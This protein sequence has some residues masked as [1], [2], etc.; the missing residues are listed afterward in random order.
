MKVEDSGDVFKKG[1]VIDSFCGRNFKI[2]LEEGICVSAV[3]AGRLC[4]HTKV[5]RG[6]EVMV[7][8]TPYNNFENGIITERLTKIPVENVVHKQDLNRGRELKAESSLKKL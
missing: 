7:R 6:D 3:L 2:K 1:I 8:L 5:I 4:K